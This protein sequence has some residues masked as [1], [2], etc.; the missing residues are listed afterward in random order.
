MALAYTPKPLVKAEVAL[1]HAG[2]DLVGH[3]V[4]APSPKFC[5]SVFTTPKA[6]VQT[7]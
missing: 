7:S 1:V 3:A 6:S 4:M 5:V 2:I